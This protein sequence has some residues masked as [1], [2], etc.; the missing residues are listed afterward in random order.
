MKTPLNFKLELQS[1]LH[2]HTS[3][4]RKKNIYQIK[5]MK[6]ELILGKCY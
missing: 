1:L 2:L 6:M 5:E 3:A 4:S